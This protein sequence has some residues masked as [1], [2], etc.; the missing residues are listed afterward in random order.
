MNGSSPPK[1]STSIR[2]KSV[3]SRPKLGLPEEVIRKWFEMLDRLTTPVAVDL[4]ID[5]PR[6]Q[7]D[8]KFLACALAAGAEYL[9]TGDRD[10]N[11]ARKLV[12]TTILSVASFKK[13]V[14]G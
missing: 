1:S 9:I 12:N 6:D 5:F 14:L 8:A 2:Y 13:L 10:F 4:T 3:L 11:E 7:K